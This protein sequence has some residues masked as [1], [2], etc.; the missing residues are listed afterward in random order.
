MAVSADE[1]REWDEYAAWTSG[2]D[3]AQYEL[4]E[5]MAWRRLQLARLKR[6]SA[7][8]GFD[9][10]AAAVNTLRRSLERG[11]PAPVLSD[12]AAEPG[13]MERERRLRDDEDDGG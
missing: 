7:P 4:T 2:A 10:D 3:P 5:E 11:L 13:W 6:R 9:L 1:Q 12:P 8:Y